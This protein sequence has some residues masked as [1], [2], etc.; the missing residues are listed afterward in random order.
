MVTIVS[1]SQPHRVQTDCCQISWIDHT[2]IVLQITDN[3]L[4]VLTHVQL[5]FT[6][7]TK[8][9]WDCS[10]RVGHEKWINNNMG[11]VKC[12]LYSVHNSQG[13]S[14]NYHLAFIDVNKG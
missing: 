9:R 13:K 12:Y 3:Y 10:F 5:R 2:F 4:F 7:T 11:E 14:K 8:F 6:S 1:I